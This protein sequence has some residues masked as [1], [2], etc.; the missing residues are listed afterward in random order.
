MTSQTTTTSPQLSD[1]DNPLDAYHSATNR[2]AVVASLCRHELED[3][4]STLDPGSPK[5][6]HLRVLIERIDAADAAWDE[7]MGRGQRS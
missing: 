2:L 4:L 6:R 7:V 5:A 1:H 3:L